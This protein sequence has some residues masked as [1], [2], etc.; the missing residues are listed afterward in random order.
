MKLAKRLSLIILKILHKSVL[1]SSL[2]NVKNII[3]KKVEICYFI[4]GRIVLVGG[5][6]K[7]LLKV[8]VLIFVVTGIT[9]VVVAKAYTGYVGFADVSIPSFQGL[10][11]G[12]TAY[13]ETSSKQYAH[14][15]H[16]YD[17][18]SHDERAIDAQVCLGS[19]C[20]AWLRL[21]TGSTKTWGNTMTMSDVQYS[22]RIRN[23][24]SLITGSSFYGDWYLDY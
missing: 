5:K 16:A 7:K 9:S 17:N 19:S 12:P 10:Y 11:Y 8:M 20:T 4:V 21:P 6:M 24:T 15:L 1:K 13:K 18:L 14:K 2:L 23:G 3:A 22:I